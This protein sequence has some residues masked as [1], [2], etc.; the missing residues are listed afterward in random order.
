M[1]NSLV[2]GVCG[3]VLK[4]AIFIWFVWMNIR[5]AIDFRWI[6][7]D[8]IFEPSTGNKALSETIRKSKDRVYILEMEVKS[9]ESA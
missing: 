8:P 2:P 3:F 7:H 9:T 6:A 1:F 4:C 5:N